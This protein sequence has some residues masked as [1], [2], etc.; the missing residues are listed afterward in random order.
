MSYD[1]A[2]AVEGFGEAGCLLGVSPVFPFS[3]AAEAQ[4]PPH[5]KKKYD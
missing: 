2:Y 1:S 5:G 3:R 4:P